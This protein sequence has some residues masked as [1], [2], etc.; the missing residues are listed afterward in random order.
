MLLEKGVVKASDT[1]GSAFT[2]ESS[3][4]DQHETD[5]AWLAIQSAEAALLSAQRERN[6]GYDSICV[7]QSELDAE[8][9]TLDSLETRNGYI[10]RSFMD[11]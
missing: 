9:K 5:Q 1:E 10:T 2:P 3:S 6:S 11:S 4:R 7:A 8:K